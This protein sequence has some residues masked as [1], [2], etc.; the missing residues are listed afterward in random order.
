MNGFRISTVLLGIPA[1]TPQIE[2]ATVPARF[3]GARVSR[4]YVNSN[5]RPPAAQKSQQTNEESTEHKHECSAKFDAPARYTVTN[6]AGIPIPVRREGH[7][8]KPVAVDTPNHL[9]AGHAKSTAHCTSVLGT[10]VSRR[11][12]RRRTLSS[13]AVMDYILAIDLPRPKLHAN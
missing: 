9:I 2:Q 6:G 13:L 10:R 11:P 7:I 5:L 12:L 3:P 1:C 4:P 8:K